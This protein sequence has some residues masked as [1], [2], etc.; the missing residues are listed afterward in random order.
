MNMEE[1]HKNFPSFEKEHTIEKK[2]KEDELKKKNSK[3]IQQKFKEQYPSL[4]FEQL[5]KQNEGIST[6]DGCI[7]YRYGLNG[8]I[9]SWN[10]DEKEW[11]EHDD[12][13]QQSLQTL[14]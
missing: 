7:H 5:T 3:I 6:D 1:F 9:Y 8:R 13:Y 11:E 14:F 10:L 2:Q 4:F 12:E